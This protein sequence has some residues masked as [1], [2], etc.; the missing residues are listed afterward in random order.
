M[1]RDT[2]QRQRPLFHEGPVWQQLD[3]PLQQQLVGGLSEMCYLIVAKA[4]SPSID[5]QEEINEH[6]ND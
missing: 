4:A 6:R 1:K 5:Q 2:S 3:P